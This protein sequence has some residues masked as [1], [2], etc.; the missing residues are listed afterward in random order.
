MTLLHE[1]QVSYKLL[2][3]R[4][5]IK[6]DEAKRYGQL[7]MLLPLRLLTS[8]PCVYA[9]SAAAPCLGCCS[10]FTMPTGTR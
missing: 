1:T 6:A 7:H 10:S 4:A 5:D 2:S 8:R 9:T 3:R